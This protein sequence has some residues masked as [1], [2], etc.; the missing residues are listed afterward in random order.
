MENKFT[1]D[2][3]VEY[4]NN[5]LKNGKH[6]WFGIGN[7]RDDP[8]MKRISTKVHSILDTKPVSVS[9]LFDVK[10]LKL[11]ENIELSTTIESEDDDNKNSAIICYFQYGE[12]SNR[13]ESLLFSVIY[14][15]LDEPSYDYLRT[16]L[17][18]GY[19]AYST[20]WNFRGILGGGFLIQ[21]GTKCPN[22]INTKIHEFLDKMNSELE[23][24]SDED[25]AKNVKAILTIK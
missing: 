7:I 9:N 1:F 15:I 8:E 12:S 17:Q 23:K 20:I 11:K 6:L 18:L 2:Q 14:Q 5:F 13:I 4:S 25:F 22:I 10:L 16:K 21:S 3:F 24:F 19:L